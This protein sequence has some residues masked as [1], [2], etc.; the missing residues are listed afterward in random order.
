MT[1]AKPV[2]LC[3]SVSVSLINYLIIILC[4][5]LLAVYKYRFH[6]WMSFPM[7]NVFL[8]LDSMN[9]WKLNEYCLL[10]GTT[11]RRV[12]LIANSCEVETCVS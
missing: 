4:S 1:S 6:T 11:G 7:F 3:F 2:R 12:M 5:D 9:R 10:L 8:K